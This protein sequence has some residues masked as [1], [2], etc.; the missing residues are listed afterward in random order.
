MKKYLHTF[1]GVITTLFGA[2]CLVSF[3]NET[4][5]WASIL[6]LLGSVIF[7]GPAVD[8]WTRVYKNFI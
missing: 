3:M 8:S 6:Y 4:F 2:F 1:L 5:S 7:L